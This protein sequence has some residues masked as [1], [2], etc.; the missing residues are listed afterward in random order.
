MIYSCCTRKSRRHPIYSLLNHY[1]FFNILLSF[2]VCIQVLTSPLIRGTTFYMHKTSGNCTLNQFIQMFVEGSQSV[3]LLLIW[4]IIL[5]ER[6]LF[7]RFQFL[8]ASYELDCALHDGTTLRA[9]IAKLREKTFSNFVIRN[10]RAFILGV[11]YSFGFVL[12]VYFSESSVYPYKSMSLCIMYS[13]GGF[14]Y[15]FRIFF[16]FMFYFPLLYYLVAAT[17]CFSSHFGGSRDSIASS[18]T[19]RDRDRLTLVKNVTLLRCVIQFLMEV[20]SSAYLVLSSTVY[21]LLR[22]F[23][24]FAIFTTTLLFFKYEGFYPKIRTRLF[25]LIGR[26]SPQDSNQR[27]GFIFRSEQNRDESSSAID[28]TNLVENENAEN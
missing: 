16:F 3:Q 15:L 14:S 7:P 21:E 26:S 11:T 22:L 9:D 4:L 17:T 5:A 18:L 24:F 12:S 13:S 10:S 20:H 23:G 25:R 19:D 6:D 2:D 27:A 28:Y 8:Y 1:L